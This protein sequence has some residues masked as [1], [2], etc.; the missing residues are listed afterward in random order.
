MQKDVRGVQAPMDDPSS[1]QR[2]DSGEELVCDVARLVDAE[3]PA[4]AE[5][6]LESGSGEPLEH[7]VD[8]AVV[9][10]ANVEDLDDVRM[11]DRGE[12][13]AFLEQGLPEARIVGE[14][15]PQDLGGADP[16]AVDALDL[17]HARRLASRELA[18]HAVAIPRQPLG[19]LRLVR[20][21]TG[22]APDL[23]SDRLFQTPP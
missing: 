9:A 17:E 2:A 16:P 14:G 19:A 12:R 10:R 22:P 3:G 11:L 15:A 6:G 23:A 8:D 7:Q 4:L 18:E 5:Q 20:V 21:L 13:L 1:V